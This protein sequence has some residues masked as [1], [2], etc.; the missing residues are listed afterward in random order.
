MKRYE[1]V[2]RGG[3]SEKQ[4]E[5]VQTE[6]RMSRWIW[7]ESR[8]GGGCGGDGGPPDEQIKL[9][10]SNIDTKTAQHKSKYKDNKI[11]LVIISI[12]HIKECSDVHLSHSVK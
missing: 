8:G 3:E 4:R 1:E 7:M 12:E 6:P 2:G 10:R 5:D 11:E 9:E